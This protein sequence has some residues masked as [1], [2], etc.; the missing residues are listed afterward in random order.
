[1]RVLTWQ[2]SCDDTW[3][4]PTWMDALR[5][6][7][8]LSPNTTAALLLLPRPSAPPFFNRPR[9]MPAPTHACIRQQAHAQVSKQSERLTA[10]PPPPPYTQESERDWPLR[11]PL[12]ASP[13]SFCP[14]FSSSA[15]SFLL[16]SSSCT[17]STSTAYLSSAL[18]LCQNRPSAW[19]TLVLACECK[20]HSAPLPTFLCSFMMSCT[21]LPC[22]A[23]P[24]TPAAHHTHP[25]TT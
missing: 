20:P 25:H 24:P 3:H 6:S 15:A 10:P 13:P 2:R 21:S 5:D 19:P 22:C 16:A 18:F 7:I 4:R 9:R 17:S 11:L 8:S 1:M 23:L 12:P 14:F